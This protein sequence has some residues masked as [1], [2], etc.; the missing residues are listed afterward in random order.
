[1]ANKSSFVLLYFSTVVRFKYKVSIFS[2]IDINK[3]RFVISNVN[4][5]I[6]SGRYSV[7]MF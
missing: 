2:F 7:K 4:S 5:I 3:G 1:M 6:I